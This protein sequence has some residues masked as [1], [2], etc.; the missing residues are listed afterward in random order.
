MHEHITHNKTYRTCREFADTLLN[1]LRH[2]VPARWATLCDS[3]TD[4]F[5]VISPAKFRILA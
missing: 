2:E 1:F 3:V 5:R 4:N